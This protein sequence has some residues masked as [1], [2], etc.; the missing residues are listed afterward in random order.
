MAVNLMEQSSKNSNFGQ[1]FISGEL[2]M[3]GPKALP[4]YPQGGVLP[5]SIVGDEAFPCCMDLMRPYLR[6]TKLN[7]LDW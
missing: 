1:Q 4:N 5:N 6:A 2:D 3:P 7:R